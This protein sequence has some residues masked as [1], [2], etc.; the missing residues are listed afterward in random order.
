MRPSSIT[1]KRL[2]SHAICR[3][4]SGSGE[5]QWAKAALEERPEARK[6]G[7]SRPLDHSGRAPRAESRMPV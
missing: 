1:R 7:P 5:A 4:S 3:L 6:S 2:S